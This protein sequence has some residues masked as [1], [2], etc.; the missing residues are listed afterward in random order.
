MLLLLILN[1]GLNIGYLYYISAHYRRSEYVVRSCLFFN[2][3]NY[4]STPQ[5]ST[6]DRTHVNVLCIATKFSINV[7]ELNR[8]LIGMVKYPLHVALIRQFQT[9]HH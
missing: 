9:A 4:V 3:A 7:A 8:N 6:L 1:V 5:S 2:L